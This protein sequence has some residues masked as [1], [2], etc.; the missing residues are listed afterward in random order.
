MMK[1][2]PVQGTAEWLEARRHLITATDLP[3]I[4]GVSPWKSEAELA[5]EKAG[6][7]PPGDETPQMRVGRAMENIVRDEYQIASGCRLRHVRR[8]VI[9]PTIPWA[10]AS[11]DFEVVGER[12]IVECKVSGRREWEEAVPQDVEAQVRWQ[13][14]VASYLV[15]DVAVWYQGRELRVHTL[16]HDADLFADLVGEAEDFRARLAAGGPFQANTAYAKRRWPRDDGATMAADADLEAAYKALVEVR[17]RLSDLG[18]TEAALEAQIKSRM[19]EVAYL[20]GTGWAISWK[21]SKDGTAVDWAGVARDALNTLA[22]ERAAE[23]VAAHTT[24][25]PGS[26]RFLVTSGKDEQR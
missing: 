9:H 3:V 19:A 12:R 2:G 24:D 26:R 17:S 21:R 18:Q 22:T 6:I 11:L 14:G 1:R 7:L 5:D 20:Q 10:A 23:I 4:L 15:A 16:H 13:M 25:K 8:M